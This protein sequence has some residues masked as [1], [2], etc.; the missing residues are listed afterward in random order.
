[1]IELLLAFGVRKGAHPYQDYTIIL[2][3]WV[4][5]LVPREKIT[6]II[7]TDIQLCEAI[8]TDDGTSINHH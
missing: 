7:V 6:S 2:L 3:S 5:D 1:M 4:R 8:D